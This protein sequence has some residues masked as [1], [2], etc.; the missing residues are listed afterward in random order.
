M[1]KMGRYISIDLEVLKKA[2]DNMTDYSET[3]KKYVKQL[4]D[5]VENISDGW[6]AEDMNAFYMHWN[7][8]FSSNGAMTISTENIENFAKLLKSAYEHY[9]KAQSDSVD[10]VMHIKG[11][12]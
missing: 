4:K 8:M 9:R 3:R 11:T 2:S 12:R 7:G 1:K 5:S 6:Q 10:Q